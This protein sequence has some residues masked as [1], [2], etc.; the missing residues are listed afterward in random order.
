MTVEER[1]ILFNRKHREEMAQITDVQT[2]PVTVI[3]NHV[4]VGHDIPA[5]E[6]AILQLG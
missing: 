5:F 4:V 1:N 2:V 3:G 6:R